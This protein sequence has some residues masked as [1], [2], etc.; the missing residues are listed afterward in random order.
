[1][2][3]SACLLQRQN[4]DHARV[5]EYSE[6][7]L[8]WQ[9]GNVKALYRAGVANLEMGDAQT[10]KQYLTQAYKEKPN[11]KNKTDKLTYKQTSVLE[12]MLGVITPFHFTNAMLC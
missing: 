11:G 12:S 1:M 6:R 4:V 5:L 7:V 3:L 8:Q 9:P 2:C 10:A